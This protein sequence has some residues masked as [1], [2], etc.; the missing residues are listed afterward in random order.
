[1][2]T[3]LFPSI[4]ALSATM[5]SCGHT[6]KAATVHITNA[7]GDKVYFQPADEQGYR[8][9]NASDTVISIE[10]LP[11]YYNFVGKDYQFHPVFLS[12]GSLTEISVDADGNVSISGTNESE[13]RFMTEHPY[14]CRTP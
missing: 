8:D 9:I 13:N 11:A 14:L 5:M 7:S 4:L 2:K 1:M 10:A 6:D 3:F 12:E